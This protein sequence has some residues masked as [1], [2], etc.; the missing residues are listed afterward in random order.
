MMAAELRLTPIILADLGENDRSATGYLPKAEFEAMA[1]AFFSR[2]D[3]SVA[4]WERAT[5]A[6]RRIVRAVDDALSMARTGGDIA[7]IAHG[8]VGALL[9]CHLRQVPISRAEDQP[10]QGGGNVFSFDAGDP[11]TDPGLAAGRG[12][13]TVRRQEM[14]MAELDGPRWG[15]ASKAAP[16]QLVVLCHGLGA[17]GHDLIDLAPTWSHAVPDALFVSVDAPFPHKSAS[18]GS[19]GAWR[20]SPAVMEAACAARPGSSTRSSMRNWHG[21]GCRRRPTR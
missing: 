12:C 16:K 14:T 13:V 7:I 19:G 20:I 17:D 18:A 3:E 1:D 6:Q 9:L 5:D 4:G 11:S 10:G 8:G 2:P 15:P 21:L